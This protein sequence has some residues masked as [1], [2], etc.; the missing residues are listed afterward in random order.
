MAQL[1][2]I[3]TKPLFD[4]SVT[5]IELHT[6]TPYAN[7][8]FQ[9]SDEIRIPIQQQD[10]YTL[11]SQSFLYVE[12]TLL[13]KTADGNGAFLPLGSARLSNNAPAFFFDEIRYE[14]NG[15][16]IDR[17][18]NV[19]A[20]SSIKTYV[21]KTPLSLGSATNAGWSPLG[22]YTTSSEGHFSFCMPLS[23]LLGFA[24][25]YKKIVINARHE[26]ILIRARTDNDAIVSA[27]ET[28]V[29]KIIKLQWKMPHV[30]VEDL[31]KMDLLHLLERSEMIQMSYRSWELYEYPTL[32]QT[33]SHT[34]SVKTSTQ[35]EKPRYVILALQSGK[36]NVRAQDPSVF[37]ALN[38]RDVKLYLNS[39]MYPYDNLE[40]DF[41][42]DRYALLYDMYVKFQPS[43]Y[44]RAFNSEP[45]LNFTEFKNKAPLVVLDCSRQNESLKSAS[46]DVRLEFQFR[47]NVPANTTMYCLIIHDRITEYN[48]LTN[49]VRKIV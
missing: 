13:S 28:S 47:D 11:P 15:V 10:L 45:L 3:D 32:P 35:L 14:L 7:A 34:W 21:S 6:H 39:D 24:E 42:K 40:L 4:N 19:G 31:R 26:L 18:K 27:E 2:N 36:R 48:P 37:Q 5:S 41:S 22:I 23:N 29:Q 30:A 17:A 38:L 25:D 46:V 12:G 33:T 8:S 43:F 44:G 16:E 1:L 9:N 20:T 49:V